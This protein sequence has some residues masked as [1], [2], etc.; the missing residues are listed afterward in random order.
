MRWKKRSYKHKLVAIGDSM[1]QGFKNGGIYRT[2]LSFP[3]L[4]ARCFNSRTSFDSPSFAAQAGIP[5]NIEILVRGL[6]EEFGDSLSWNQ[7]LPVAK[8]L[9]STLRRI[10]NHWE[11]EKN[12]INIERKIPYH[13][14]GV[15]G[16]AA[17]DSWLMTSKICR[18]YFYK[19]KPRYSIFSILPDHAMYITGRLVLNPGFKP[20]YENC[21]QIGNV[22]RLNDDGGVE[23]LIVCTGHN[24][25]AGALSSLKIVFTDD[26]FLDKHRYERDFTVYQPEHFEMEMRHL[27]EK[28]APLDIPNVFVPTL[29]YMTIPPVTRGVNEN[30]SPNH[31]GYFD[32]YT[33]FWIWD[34]D[35]DPDKHPHLTKKEAILLDQLI[36]RYN[37]IIRNLAEEF[38]FHVVPVGK[39][40]SAVA[41]RRMGVNSVK[42][43]PDGLI[44]ALKNHTSTSHLVEP[45]GTVGL[46]TDF[47][48]VNEKT[49]KIYQGGIFS[50]DG[51]HPSTIGYGMIAD[52]YKKVMEQVG[53]EFEK[54]MDWEFILEN[55][56]LVTDPPYLLA[57]LR[58]LLRFLSLGRQERITKIGQ[59]ILQQLLDMFGRTRSDEIEQV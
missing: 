6:S 52:V 30:R 34:D 42:P 46:S 1:A 55:E 25:I 23:N 51:L 8:N 5:I 2:D 59:N 45:N 16:F 4:L 11:D 19:N 38:G 15:W 22:K 53:V 27:Y 43:F 58:L 57:E 32:Y 14:Q 39:H 9:Y 50:L 13:N 12:H 7:F 56:T 33:R 17:N 49:R 29:P 26:G 3:A 28:I 35:F 10:K 18:E 48:R 40:V 31:S 54:P 47:L 20:E 44:K 21:S 36:D 37:M 24:N 41:R